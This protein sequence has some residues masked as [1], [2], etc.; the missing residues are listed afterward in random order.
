LSEYRIWYLNYRF[1]S[2]CYFSIIPQLCSS[3]I[4]NYFYGNDYFFDCFSLG[5]SIH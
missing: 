3:R 1:Q 5:T 2:F 4:E